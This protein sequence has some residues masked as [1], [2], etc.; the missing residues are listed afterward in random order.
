[1]RISRRGTGDATLVPNTDLTQT[2]PANW[3]NFEFD[4]TFGT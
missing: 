1:M 3:L 2:I 4:N